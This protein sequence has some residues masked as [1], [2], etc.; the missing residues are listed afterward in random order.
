METEMESP[1][2][3]SRRRR[4]RDHGG[5]DEDRDDLDDRDREGVDGGEDAAGARRGSG[6]DLGKNELEGHTLWK[7]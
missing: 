6:A 5:D 2:C 4:R 3:R 1:R 7:L